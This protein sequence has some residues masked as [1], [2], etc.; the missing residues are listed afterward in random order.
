MSDT[1]ILSRIHTIPPV[2]TKFVAGRWHHDRAALDGFLVEARVF[3]KSKIVPH[4]DN[5][6]FLV[7]GRARSGT[8]LLTRLLNGH[9]HIHCDGEV[10]KYNMLSPRRHFER[11]AGKS[12]SRIYGAKVLSHQM[13]QVHRMRQPQKFLG[14]L[15]AHGVHLIHLERDTFFQTLSLTIAQRRKQYHSHKGAEALEQKIYLEPQEFLSRLSWNEALLSYER[16]ALLDLPNTHILYEQ[17]L[18]S[19]A[20]QKRTLERIYNVLG[21]PAEPMNTPIRKILP[22]TP[23]DIIENYDEI[24]QAIEKSGRSYLLSNV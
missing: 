20:I 17:D 13:V 18:G 1:E 22:S 16:A 8:T 12:S 3:L 11:L 14:K 5:K 15:V 24:H 10:L 6:R 9:S 23:E 21:V 7:L 4:N 19:T 2:D